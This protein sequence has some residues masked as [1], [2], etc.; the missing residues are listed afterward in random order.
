MG[1]PIFPYELTDPD[2][3]WLIGNYREN[4]PKS[5]SVESTCLPVVFISEDE[6]ASTDQEL[7]MPDPVEEKEPRILNK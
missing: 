2:F 4:N 1:R 3:T 5:I 6:Q 7:F